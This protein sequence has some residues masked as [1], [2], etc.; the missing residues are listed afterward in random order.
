[1][2][3]FCAA[4]ARLRCQGGIGLMS[5]RVPSASIGAPLF[6]GSLSRNTR[7]RRPSVSSAPF[8]FRFTS[9]ASTKVDVQKGGKG[10]K[11]K[12]GKGHE[13]GVTPRSEDFGKWYLDVLKA[14]ELADYGPVRGT[15]VIRPYGYAIWE[16]VQSWLDTEFKRTGHQNCYFP[17]LIPYSF[18]EKESN[19]VEG[20]SPELALVTQGGGKE[21]EEPLVMRP[22]SETMVNHMFSQWVKSYRD[23]PLLV[24]QWCN[25]TRWEMRTRPFVRTL[26][27]LWQ[28]GHTA[29]STAEEAEEETVRMIRMYEEFATKM[30]AMPVVTGRKSKIE[31]FA[32][33]DCTYT[34]EAMMGDKRALQAGTSHNLGQ[35]FAKA[36]DIK[37]LDQDGE[38]KHVHQ[39]SWGVSTRMVGGIIMSHGDDKGLKLPPFLA[40]IQVVIL[41]IGKKEDQLKAVNACAQEVHDALQAS[42]IR[43]KVDSST[44]KSPGWKF[45]YWEMK[46]VPVRIEIGARDLETNSC[47]VARR[48]KPGKDGKTFGVPVESESLANLVKST[49]A[50]IQDGMLEEAKQFRDSNIVDVAT[51]EE[52]KAAVEEG[53]W[54]RGYWVG[55]D[56]LEEKIKEETGATLRCFPFEQPAGDGQCFMTQA[57]AKE[58][59]IFAKSY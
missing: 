10:Q 38:L 15:M 1:M 11:H 53:K 20:F 29:H 18:I 51:Y 39:T 48:D 28:E 52:L 14:A 45:N 54:A 27:F 58:V 6:G 31:S 4:R 26:E 36:F 35:N 21:L 43:C 16:Q 47:V 50:S 57:E 59:A 19:H 56:E 24:N 49:L 46:G 17:Q 22:T 33:A 32:G 25:V 2:R 13:E 7:R 44:G 37:Y 34:I 12:G 8:R 40:P 30:A 23:L 41:P 9:A 3:P 5:P 55:S 42:G